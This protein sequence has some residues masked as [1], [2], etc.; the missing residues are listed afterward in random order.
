V[1][2]FTPIAILVFVVVAT[3][4]IAVATPSVDPSLISRLTL[5][6]SK[7]ERLNE[8]EK[9]YLD[10]YTILRDDNECSR[11]YGGPAA[12]EALNEMVRVLRPAYIDRHIAVRM[13]GATTMFRNGASGFSF[14]MFEKAEINMRGAFYRSNSPSENRVP[15]VADY[16]P[17]T[18][19]TRVALLLHELGHLVRGA[20]RKWVLS[21]DGNNIDLSIKNTEYVVDVCR[22]EI[23]HV[24]RLTVAQQLEKPLT[25][26]AQMATL[27]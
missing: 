1:K 13:S 9:A 27:P 16:Q 3:G 18:R 26:V 12:I 24:T 8:L 11:L 23:E 2:K 6:A 17:N 5:L 15:L 7:N 14:R 10:V 25:T 19:R 21:D 4:R 22:E 20:D